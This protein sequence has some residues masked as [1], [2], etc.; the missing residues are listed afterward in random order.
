MLFLSFLLNIS[1][2]HNLSSKKEKYFK[3]NDHRIQFQNNN[4]S[5]V[6]SF[7]NIAICKVP[8]MMQPAGLLHPPFATEC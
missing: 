2:F 1:F 5:R 7:N 6:L 8:N 3:Y 4:V